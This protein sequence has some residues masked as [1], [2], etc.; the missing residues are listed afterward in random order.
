MASRRQ[1]DVFRRAGRRSTPQRRLILD[2]LEGGA[3]HL[4]AEAVHDRVKTRDPR[5]SLATVYR[6]LAVLRTMGLIVEH[7]LGEQ[8]GHYELVR[9]G[10]H[11]HFTCRR[12][13]AVIEF[14][15]PGVAAIMRELSE[16]RGVKVSEVHLSAVGLCARCAKKPGP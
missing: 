9:D 10:P 2:V 1:D 13:G 7:R 15:A 6:S 14:G 16:R 5:I 11:Y 3:G 4:D 8:H 12:C